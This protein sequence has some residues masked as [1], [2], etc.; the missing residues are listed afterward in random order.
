LQQETKT[1]LSSVDKKNLTSKLILETNE[2]F[3]SSAKKRIL[4]DF[5]MPPSKFKKSEEDLFENITT[6][7]TQIES[8]PSQL[9]PPQKSKFQMEDS[10]S[11]GKQLPLIIQGYSLHP[12]RD[13]RLH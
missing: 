5:E 2:S 12:Q 13:P 7:C 3:G 1:F 6:G 4:E 10:P 8:P 9:T 11:R